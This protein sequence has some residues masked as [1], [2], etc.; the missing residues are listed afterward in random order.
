MAQALVPGEAAFEVASQAL[1]QTCIRFAA[2]ICHFSLFL[3]AVSGK[4]IQIR[5]DVVSDL[6]QLCD[7]FGFWSL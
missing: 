5:N 7:Q 6:L 3:E 4:E 2:L 1:R